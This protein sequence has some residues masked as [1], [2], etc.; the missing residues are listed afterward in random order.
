MFTSFRESVE[1]YADDF[2]MLTE[3]D[4]VRLVSHYGNL[5]WHEWTVEA[6]RLGVPQLS[7]HEIL[8]W[9]GY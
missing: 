9:L 4:A 8:C 2:G 1:Y 6:G 3:R 5:P 7:A